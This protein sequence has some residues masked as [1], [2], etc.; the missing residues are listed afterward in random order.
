MFSPEQILQYT[1]WSGYLTLFFAALAL[2]GW[3][4]K[5]GLRFRLVGATGFMLVLTAGLFALNLGLYNRPTIPGAVRFSRVFDMGSTELVI[6]V[7][8]NINETE[9]EATLQQAAADLY[10]SGRLSQGTDHMTIRARTVLHPEP[11][12][13]QPV[14]LGQVKRSLLSRNDDQ[15]AIELY[16]DKLAQLPQG[17]K[18]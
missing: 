15:M 11:G 10:S 1:Q 12:I 6:A 3:L 16:R 18:G 8:P 14:Y 13:S 7:P 2:L 17:G 9:L 5:W 4:L